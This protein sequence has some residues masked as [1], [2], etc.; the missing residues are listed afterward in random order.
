MEE[1]TDKD[2]AEDKVTRESED[3]LSEEELDEVS[4]G[5]K[6]GGPPPEYNY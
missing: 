2:K 1:D 5:R 6:A 3:E 4:G